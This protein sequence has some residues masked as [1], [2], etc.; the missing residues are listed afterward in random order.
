MKDCMAVL[1]VNCFIHVYCVTYVVLPRKVYRVRGVWP[2][3]VINL[4]S[5]FLCVLPGVN[6]IP[7]LVTCVLFF[8][9]MVAISIKQQCSNIAGLFLFIL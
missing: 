7:L 3:D 1:R 2:I 8:I 4:Y 5:M 6:L 9:R